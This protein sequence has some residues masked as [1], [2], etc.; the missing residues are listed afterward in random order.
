MGEATRMVSGSLKPIAASAWDEG[1]A[2]HLLWR[3]G[4]GGTPG[5]VAYLAGLGAEGA[6][7]ALLDFEKTTGTPAEAPEGFDD[8]IMAPPTE[9]Q[10]KEVQRARRARDEDALAR[11]RL[12]RQ[13]KEQADRK[14]MSQLQRW[15]LKRLIESPR[16]MEEKLA[17]FW[18]G[19]FAT[20]YRTIENSS[21]MFMQNQL[22]RRHA[23]GNFGELLHA[24]VRDPAMIGYL[25]NNESRKGKPNENLAR[26]LMEL[27]SLG[28]GNYSEQDIREGARALTGYSFE[29]N[30]F[31]FRK[32]WHDE[33][34][35][36]VLGRNGVQDG[37]G[38]VNAILAK[39]EAAE[40]ITMKLYRHLVN[41]L[42]TEGEA[43]RVVI[44]VVRQ[45]ASTLAAARYELKPMLRRLLLSEHFY[46]RAN[47]LNRIK[48]PVELV[49]GIVRSLGTPVRDLGVLNDGLDLMGQSLFYPPSV[50]GWEGGRSWINTST[51]FVRQNI[52]NFL[53][54]GKTPGGYDALA[55][56]ERYD[57]R[58]MVAEAKKRLG[59]AE[60]DA[61]GVAR[62]L[63]EFCLGRSVEEEKERAIA[64][65]LGSFGALDETGVARTLAL[66]CATAEYQL[67]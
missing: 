49:V 2:R 22:F 25:D 9:S 54:T 53:L 18:H 27:F 4:F 58:P 30:S 7:S 41:D 5:Q 55:E 16:P 35:K 14:Q 51:F 43:R 10:R 19:H 24:V 34:T 33:G 62:C 13:Q 63:I 59:G 56:K 67:C 40:F 8:S 20:S 52:A 42:P 66:I 61:A 32:E 46:D 17:I 23:A 26:E 65:Y 36:Q 3:A 47:R 39:R 29:H 48:S 37:E 57:F 12:L 21:H 1:C 64:E 15:W 45:L 11:V 31:V 6:V 44:G 38:F 50:K 60:L 28:E